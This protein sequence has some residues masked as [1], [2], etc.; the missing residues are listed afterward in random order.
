MT[1][2]ITILC[3]IIDNL[4]DAG[5]TLRLARQW[6]HQRPSDSIEIYTDNIQPF[7]ILSDLPVLSN[8]DQSFLNTDCSIHLLEKCKI[9]L[10]KEP[11]TIDDW[12]DI[13]IEMFGTPISHIWKSLLAHRTPKVQW[14]NLEYLSAEKWVEDF[15]GYY[16]I[17]PESK[18]QQLF[19]FPGFSN[20]TGGLLGPENNTNLINNAPPN[21]SQR[22]NIF[23]FAYD[24]EPLK[25]WLS[26]FEYTRK[27]IT[28]HVSGNF[29]STLKDTSLVQKTPF[30]PQTEF[31]T[32]LQGF[33]YL[34]V[35]GEDSFVRAQLSGKPFIWQIYP[36]NDKTHWDKLEAFYSL[37]ASDLPEPIR[38]LWQQ[39][40]FFWN[41][42]QNI[43][44][45]CLNKALAYNDTLTAHALNWKQKI[46]PE[47]T[48]IQRLHKALGLF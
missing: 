27:P 45:N 19:F 2:K 18:W 10:K 34:L 6:L 5:V 36:T 48:L 23:V 44:T 7:L 20:K 42:K 22:L 12:G 32:L 8:S 14:V 31:D 33:D 11:N 38:S 26:F 13:V 25:K 24:F 47:C 4:G 29:E 40:W 15:H 21:N 30:V 41:G 37:Y 28:F 17:D 3:Q 35:R 9:F 46:L 43:N 1:T 39:V 16:S